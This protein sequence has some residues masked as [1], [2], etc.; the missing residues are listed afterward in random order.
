MAE[1]KTSTSETTKTTMT[2]KKAKTA[3]GTRT[4]AEVKARGFD[5]AVYGF[6]K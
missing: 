3:K 1:T 2:A 4:A 6:K 5:P